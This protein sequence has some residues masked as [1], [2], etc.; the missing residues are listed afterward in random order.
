MKHNIY[1]ISLLFITFFFLT[2]CNDDTISE[3]HYNPEVVVK[4]SNLNYDQPGFLNLFPEIESLNNIS[5][6]FTSDY[7]EERKNRLLINMQIKVANWGQ[8]VAVMDNILTATGCNTVG[9]YILPT[10]AERAKYNGQDAW[11]IQFTYALDTLVF[12]RFK[13]FAFS[14]PDLDTLCYLGSH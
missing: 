11:L 6:A 1:L 2:A 9:E 8:D 12:G 5:T 3:S 13:C 14:I 4:V 7:S 10:Y